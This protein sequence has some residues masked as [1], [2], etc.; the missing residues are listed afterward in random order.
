ML[1]LRR[2]YKPGGHAERSHRLAGAPASKRWCWRRCCPSR[3]IWTQH[4]TP[5]LKR[6]CPAN[7][8]LLSCACAS[9]RGERCCT[10]ETTWSTLRSMNYASCRPPCWTHW[11]RTRNKPAST[12]GARTLPWRCAP[13]HTPTP[14]RCS[15]ASL[16][17]PLMT[18]PGPVPVS[19]W[20]RPLT[21]SGATMQ[22]GRPCRMRMQHN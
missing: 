20:P 21:V 19:A 8:R 12:V 9:P 16:P 2:Q 13:A 1:R 11:R 4:C 15:A 14:R 7:R 22:L 6:N 5:W 10:K 17:L 3:A 18:K